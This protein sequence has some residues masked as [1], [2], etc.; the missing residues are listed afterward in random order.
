MADV[1]EKPE[2][3]RQATARVELHASAKVMAAIQKQSLPKGDVIAAAQI[4]GIEA[5]KRTSEI[6]PLCHPLRI[7]HVAVDFH[8]NRN[9]VV[10][11]A[12][13]TAKEQT[14]VEME[15]LTA[16]SVAALTLY[17]M[18]KSIDR[19]IE[20]AHL[21]LLKKSGGKSGTWVRKK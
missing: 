21:C 8:L 15:A 2:T 6:I 19:G 5:A 11:L 12:K 17:D 3:L 1:S 13:V 20:I 10:I 14:G 18:T 4:A 7:S 16:A 9:Q